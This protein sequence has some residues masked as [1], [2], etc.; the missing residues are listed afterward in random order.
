MSR[1]RSVFLLRKMMTNASHM[2][3]SRQYLIFVSKE[4]RSYLITAETFFLFFYTLELTLRFFSFREKL[5]ALKDFWFR[6]D[7][8]LVFLMW[9]EIVLTLIGYLDKL[10]QIPGVGEIRVVFLTEGS[11]VELR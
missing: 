10:E 7:G 9:L 1:S 2:G 11:G 6:Y 4:V 5:F 8:V 3:N